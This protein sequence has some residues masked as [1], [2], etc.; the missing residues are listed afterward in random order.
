MWRIDKREIELTNPDGG[1]FRLT[2]T[3]SQTSLARFSTVYAPLVTYR[4]RI[5]AVKKLDM[6]LLVLDS[7]LKQQLKLVSKLSQF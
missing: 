4:G 2:R 3:G 7:P 1:K 6:D 5:F